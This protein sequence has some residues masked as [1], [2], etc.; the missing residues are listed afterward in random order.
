MD[1]TREGSRTTTE[2]IHLPVQDSPRQL[3]EK[4]IPC[5]GIFGTPPRFSYDRAVLDTIS[6]TIGGSHPEQGGILGGN[7]TTGKVTHFFFDHTAQRTGA[8]YSPDHRLLTKLLRNKWNPAGIDLVGF[9]H[10]HPPSAR[11]LSSG[12]IQYARRILEDNPS[13][14][15]LLL[16]I[17]LPQASTGVSSS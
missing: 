17:A 7:R 9:V 12:D 4:G 13:M 16:P 1:K 11:H 3:P 15:R 6:S 5:G 8:T 14:K 10:G 2:S